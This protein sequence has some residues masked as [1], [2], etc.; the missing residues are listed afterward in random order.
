VLDDRLGSKAWEILASDISSRVL[1][2][3]RQ[4]RYSMERAEKIHKEYLTKCCLK[5]VGAHAGM[6]MID[7]RLRSRIQFRSLN[8]N[9]KLPDVGSFDVVFLRNVMI[10]FD[11]DTKRQIV[12]RLAATLVPGGYLFIGHSESLHGITDVVKAVQP[13]IYQKP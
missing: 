5:G 13:A 4:G 11:A 2:H 10:Y 6:F 1:E 8:L 7:Q 12:E 9:Q 3:A